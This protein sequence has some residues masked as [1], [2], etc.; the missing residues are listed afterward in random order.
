MINHFIHKMILSE[1]F[2]YNIFKILKLEYYYNIKIVLRLPYFKIRYSFS[3]VPIHL[4]PQAENKY[5][6]NIFII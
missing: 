6:Y 1:S 3:K 2:N 4:I 5:R